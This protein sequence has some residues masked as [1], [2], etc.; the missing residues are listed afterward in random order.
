MPQNIH[1]YLNPEGNGT[2]KT[3]SYRQTLRCRLGTIQLPW[4]AKF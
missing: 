3:L 1:G 4:E 2:M